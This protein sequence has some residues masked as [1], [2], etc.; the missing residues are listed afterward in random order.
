MAN[1]T[2]PGS[3]GRSAGSDGRSEGYPH[4][5]IPTGFIFGFI[6]IAVGVVLLLDNLGVVRA[7]DFFRLWPLA[8]V[9]VGVSKLAE[10][11][12]SGGR[13]W[14][15]VL[16]I[17]GVAL[18]LRN[19]GYVEIQFSVIWPLML[20]GF[21]LSLLWGALEREKYRGKSRPESAVNSLNEWAIFGGG[22]RRV[23]T[24]DFQGGEVLAIFGGYQIDL[25]NARMT[26]DEV[27]IDANA[28]FGG[29][30][31]RVPETW[32]VNTQGV[33]LFGGYEDKSAQPKPDTPGLKR[34]VIKGF[35]IF[36]GVEVRN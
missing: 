11:R 29:V 1:E 31:I 19:L 2:R 35:A 36:G 8:F 30:E 18:L 32:S 34:L 23:N 5:A 13:L 3:D 33:G 6:I 22:K 17:A 10:S 24:D 4:R 15:A 14:G 9:A 7:H 27:R 21:G 26:F 12:G 16:T 28:M 20:I 25:R